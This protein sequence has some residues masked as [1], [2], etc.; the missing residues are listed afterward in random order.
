MKNLRSVFIALLLI[1]LSFGGITT[2][3][4]AAPPGWSST[5]LIVDPIK[6]ESGYVAGTVI[7]DPENA[8]HI[9]RGIPYAAP[10]VGDRR[11]KA[12]QAVG[13]WEGIREA[14]QFSPIAIQTGGPFL[15]MGLTESEDCLYLN[16]VTPAKHRHKKL[17]VMVWFHGGGFDNST[18]NDPLF[19]NYRLPEFGVVT[20]A[21]IHRLGALG[22]L[23][24]PALTAESGVSGN[25]MV[26]DMIASLQWVKKNIAAFGGDPH[27]ITVFG[28]SG[29]G[30]KVGALIASPA[31]KGLVQ[32]G[33]CESGSAGTALNLAAVEAM[34]QKVFE[35]LGVTTLADA[36]Q[37]TPQEIVAADQAAR[38]ELGV[39]GWSM[40]IDDKYFFEGPIDT[41][42]AGKQAPVPMI[43]SANL[44][45]LGPGLISMPQVIGDYVEM[46][47]G[48]NKVGQN[49]Y[50]TIFDQVPQNWRNQGGVAT[51]AIEL[52]Y[53]FGDYDLSTPYTWPLIFALESFYG[54]TDPLP[55]LTEADRIT[56]EATMAMWAQ[57]AKTGNP[58][59]KKMPVWPAWKPGTD[60]YMYI[61]YN[62]SNTR[63]PLNVETGF[64]ELP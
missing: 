11:W 64:S 32:K 59:V 4:S 47:K 41:F 46:L 45:E 17:P 57:F 34:G 27:N 2:S 63:V 16:V 22:L 7:G 18:G 30:A 28:E 50:A 25:Y 53:V 35:K 52:A 55:V 23:A 61:R 10:P 8:V 51:H 21:V 1:A 20:V 44:G 33:I 49:G 29:G 37:K 6:I 19:N 58:S 26:L 36:R 39:R 12:P 15:S 5:D 48:V 14:T 56:S 40:T 24:H 62:P 13:P 38:A 9:Y 3:S 31:A 43:V 54:V 60:K 42:K